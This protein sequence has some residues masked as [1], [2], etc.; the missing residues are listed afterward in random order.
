MS[1][2]RLP[3]K[4]LFAALALCAALAGIGAAVVMAAQPTSNGRHAGH[5]GRAHKA[6]RA[7]THE[8]DLFASAASYLGL[9]RSQLRAE[10]RSGKSLAQ[11]AAA[12]PGKSASG[13]VTTLEAA[14]KAKLSASAARLSSRIAAIV[15]STGGRRHARTR[16]LSAAA[17][18]LGLSRMKLHQDLRSGDTLAQV[19]K[20]TSGKSEAGL[21]QALVAARKAAIATAVGAHA[22]SQAQANSLSAKLNE[23][24]S[25][26]VNRVHH[27]Q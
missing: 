1:M 5:A 18:Y 25:A 23:R 8:H 10:L 21:V 12:T 26:Q 14:A 3:K 15:N 7:R 24:V 22:I 20:S 19:A 16:A 27:A 6:G 4:K 13:L 11:I 2:S 9:S 17:T